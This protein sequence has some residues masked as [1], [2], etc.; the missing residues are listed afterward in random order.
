MN[1][2]RKTRLLIVCHTM[3]RGGM[4]EVVLTT[5]RNLDKARFDVHV[6]YFKGGEVAEKLRKVPGVTAVHVDE[7]RRV[8]RLT[9]LHS[10]AKALKPEIVHNHFCWYG[11]IIGVLAGARRVETVH[12]VYSWFTPLQRWAF[13]VQCLLANRI[14]A[15]SEEVRRYTV[16]H[17]PFVKKNKMIVIHNGIDADTSLPPI[18][19]DL[20]A[21]FGL[22][23]ED[24]VA[25]FAGRLE[26]EKGIDRLLEVWAR[27]E[28]TQPNFRLVVFGDGSEAGRLRTLARDLGL[29]SVVFA[30]FRPDMQRLYAMLDVFVLPSLYEGLP[31]S[32]LEAMAAGCP[33]IATSVGGVPEAVDDGVQGYLV[34]PGDSDALLDRLA[35]LL[36]DKTG[37][38]RMGRAA[39]ERVAGE[40]TAGRMARKLEELYEGLGHAAR[41]SA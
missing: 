32:L 1:S 37:R 22:R 11:Q 10:Y 13:A 8:R 31:L 29:R 17:I 34:P 15:V 6:A 19:D 35:K 39:R 30:G 38:I 12:N 2:D 20:K 21:G 7:K 4:E 5:V 24:V 41:S 3:D 26:P 27:L 25:G 18:S 36:S 33:V 28:K 9:K 16:T 14:V 40:F 23:P